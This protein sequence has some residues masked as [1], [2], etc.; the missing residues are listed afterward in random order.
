MEVRDSPGLPERQKKVLEHLRN[1]GALTSG[2]IARLLKINPVKAR[3]ALIALKTRRLI[4]ARY[5]NGVRVWVAAPFS[6]I[7]KALVYGALYTKLKLEQPDWQFTINSD[8][9]VITKPDGKVIKTLYVKEGEVARKADLYIVK[10]KPTLRKGSKFT[11]EEILFSDKPLLE[12][13]YLIN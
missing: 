4:V 13:I 7:E 11:T 1:A 5:H 9:A 6:N 2:M 10:G 3:R 12:N 8:T